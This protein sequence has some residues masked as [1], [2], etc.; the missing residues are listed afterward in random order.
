MRKFSDFKISTKMI[1]C[2]MIVAVIVLIVAIVGYINMKNINDGTTRLY[3]E[4]TLPI[5]NLGVA[6]KLMYKLRG[7][8][9]SNL[10]LQNDIDSMRQKADTDIASINQQMNAYRSI[11]LL[12]EEKELL[13]QYDT[14]W[15]AYQKIID[16]IIEKSTSGDMEGAKTTIAN[17]ATA[18]SRNTVDNTLG[19]LEEIRTGLAE[20]T[21]LQSEATFNTAILM[22]IIAGILGVLLAIGLGLFLS[23]S[24]T[25]P[26][27]LVAQSSQQIAEIDLKTLANEMGFLAKGDLTRMLKITSQPLQVES[28]DEVG[29][30]AQAFNAMINR[31]QETGEAFSRMC[32]KLNG[33]LLETSLITNQVAQGVAQVR[34]VS[35]DLATNSQE[36]SSALEEISANLEETNAQVKTNS[37][38]S[39][40]SNQL[41]LKTSELTSS[42]QAKMQDMSVAVE[43]IAKSSQEIAKIIKVIDDIAFQTNLLALN[44]AVEAARAGQHGRGFAVVAQEVRNLAERSA[45]AAKET[46]TLIEGSTNR[47]QEGVK[48]STEVAKAMENA[49]QNVLKLRDIAAEVAAASEEQAKALAQINIAMLQVNQ[50]AQ[51]G[52]TQSEELA[53]AADELASQADKLRSEVTRFRLRRRKNSDDDSQEED[54]YWR[55]QGSAYEHPKTP[56]SYT[57][58]D[59]I[60]IDQDERGYGQF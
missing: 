41:A 6:V 54:D 43:A 24:I 19:K 45:K 21:H 53:S 56:H 55:Q 38:N 7:D 16:E 29:Q 27:Q 46:A 47:V 8:L 44:A 52:S 35:Q 23:R 20:E 51:S 2:F 32:S 12:P 58:S 10:L 33:T 9:L 40:I 57:Q 15:E 22:M 1:F 18:Q 42:G 3:T 14:A 13:E 30:L 4:N 26:L 34:A 11:S 60:E 17:P 28:K 49:D 31:L 37:E 59:S 50:G 36:Q 5:E 48:V 39:N 25:R